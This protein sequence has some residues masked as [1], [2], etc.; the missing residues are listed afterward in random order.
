M[1]PVEPEAV[2]PGQPGVRRSDDSVIVPAAV[3]SAEDRT[4]SVRATGGMTT[5]RATM[6]LSATAV[7]ERAP[8]AAATPIA[9]AARPAVPCAVL[10]DAPPVAARLARDDRP[11]RNPSLSHVAEHCV[12]PGRPGRSFGAR[13]WTP[14]ATP[15]SAAELVRDARSPRRPGS[16]RTR[17]RW[18]A[19][20]APTRHGVDS[21][22]APAA[23][24]CSTIPTSRTPWGGAVPR[25]SAS[26]RRPSSPTSASTRC[27]PMSRGPGSIDALDVRGARLPRRIGHRDQDRSPPASARSPARATARRSSCAPRGRRR[28]RDRRRTSRPGRTALH[29]RRAPAGLGRGR[30]AP[31]HAE[32]RVTEPTSGRSTRRDAALESSTTR[33]RTDAVA[34]SPRAPAGRGRRRA[35]IRVPLLAARLPHPGLPPRRGRRS[36]ST[37]PPIGGLHRR[38]QAA[39]GDEEW[40]LHA[41]SQ[42]L[43][44]LR[45][46]GLDPD[47]H[48]RH[49]ARRPAARACRASGSAPS[50][51]R[52]LGIHLA[53]EHSAAD[54][55][56]RPLPQSLA[57][58][59]RARRRAPRRRA[60]R[61][62]ARARS[63]RARPRSPPQEFEAVLERETE[64][65]AAGAVAAPQRASTRV[66]GRATSRSPASCGPRATTTPAR[67]TSRP[68]GSCPTR[69]SSPPR[70]RCPATKQDLAGDQGVHRPREPQRSST[71]GGRRSRRGIADRRSA[72]RARPPSDSLPP[73]AR[74]GRQATRRPTRRLKARTR[75]VVE[76]RPSELDMP[77]R[78]PAHARSAAPRRVDSARADDRG[79]RRRGPRGARRAPL[80][81]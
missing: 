15:R 69:R 71:A 66:R 31:A 20:C 60:R 27:S 54:W 78:E 68:A 48:L 3:S 9:I 30:P 12:R 26:P 45:E 10:A 80:A 36:C 70:A 59:R 21:A 14:C 53:K 7:D 43:A 35:R 37:R 17:S 2:S 25:S 62:S 65:A 61:R 55:S 76:A 34:R 41:A 32:R 5:V 16:P 1:S 42:D 4:S 13:R 44:C 18:P 74:L 19:T 40:V 46:L 49:R 64:A 51:R 39:I 33:S 6:T 81:D 28:R 24:S 72:A 79:D 29:A 57:R 11:T 73:P 47:A 50:S 67:S 77:A 52:L 22:S 75:R 58:V 38:S 23:S 8:A 63:S 56:T